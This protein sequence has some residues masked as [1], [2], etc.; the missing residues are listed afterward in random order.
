MASRI[1]E[2]ESCDQL[3]LTYLQEANTLIQKCQQY[4]HIKGMQKLEKKCRA[5]LKYLQSLRKK[6]DFIHESQLKSS[7]LCHFAGILHAM[8]VIPGVVSMMTAVHSP[9]RTS[10]LHVDIVAGQGQVWVKVIARKAQALHLIWAG[11]GQFGEHNLI[12]QAED[13]ITCAKS[14]PVNFCPPSLHFAFYSQ[15]TILMAEALEELGVKVWGERV[16]VDPD[17]ETQLKALS[18]IY[19]DSDEESEDLPDEESEESSTGNNQPS[20]I[21]KDLGTHFSTHT[22][23]DSVLDCVLPVTV[24]GLPVSNKGLPV[25]ESGVPVSDTG[26]PVTVS[27]LPV[28]DK[29]LPVSDKGLP[30]SDKGL[31]VSESGVPVSD[32]GLP[33]SESGAPVS[34]TGL[35]VSES[36]ASVSNTGLPVSE[37]GAPVSDTR[38]PVSKSGTPVLESRISVLDSGLHVSNRDFIASDRK[39]PVPKNVDALHEVENSDNT[40]T[41]GERSF[42]TSANKNCEDL[43]QDLDKDTCNSEC[44]KESSNLRKSFPS[45]CQTD[46]DLTEPSCSTAVHQT[47][48]SKH[49]NQIR[50]TD[51]SNQVKVTGLKQPVCVASNSAELNLQP[52]KR[53]SSEGISEIYNDLFISCLLIS[54]PKYDVS[55][56]VISAESCNSDKS[57]NSGKVNLDITTLITLVSAVTHGGCHF[58]FPEKILTLQAKDERENP[59]LPQLQTYLN[60]KELYAC[61]TAW[62]DFETILKTLG[63]PEEKRRA[64]LLLHRVKVIPDQPSKRAKD[65]P[66]TG[67]IR[68]RTKVIFGTGDELGAVTTTA[69]MG[70]VRAAEHQGVSFAIYSHSSR[71]LTEDKEKNATPLDDLSASSSERKF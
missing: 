29:G 23:L 11:E 54:V 32:E 4:Q 3:L 26:L 5:E 49:L 37:S 57:V 13:Y 20:I 63:G 30:V 12:K 7:N 19:L 10:S 51:S 25:S 64:Q 71:A 8:Q 44:T 43:Y 67:K 69:N 6:T 68:Q 56:M 55:K 52:Q 61:Q 38:L 21:D 42:H 35:P 2:E 47:K 22:R 34:D 17:I 58:I 9:N 14:N 66:D 1:G 45:L 40:P 62:D 59:A 39:I 60:G 41:V 33:V 18:A 15:V 27:G 50:K 31:P 70:F 36:G 16:A 46:T 24:T 53:N 65:L 28:S 48:S